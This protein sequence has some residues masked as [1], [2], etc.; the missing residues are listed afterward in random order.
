LRP[1]T[2]SPKIR[3]AVA[4]RTAS[5]VT[6]YRSSPQV[7]QPVL[8]PVWPQSIEAARSLDLLAIAGVNVGDMC[9]KDRAIRRV[10]IHATHLSTW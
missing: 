6:I 9:T 10:V 7:G 2:T 4:N 8:T 3:T 1:A 5:A